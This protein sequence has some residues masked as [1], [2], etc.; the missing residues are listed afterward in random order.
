MPKSRRNKV[1]HMTQVSKK[2]RE[3][4]EQLLE[5]IREAIPEY[6]HIFVFGIENMRNTHIQEVRKE[7]RDDSRYVFFLPLPPTVHL[8]QIN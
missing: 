4:K 1:V 8:D 5:T 2:T 6:Q 3:H 7:L